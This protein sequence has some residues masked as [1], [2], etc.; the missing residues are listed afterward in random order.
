MGYSRRDGIVRAWLSS[1]AVLA[2]A[3]GPGRVSAQDKSGAERKLAGKTVAILVADAF[4]Q[5]ELTGPRKALEAG[6]KTVLVSPH[7]GQVRAWN[8]TNWGDIFDVDRPLD[9]A[10]PE[11]FDALLLSGGVG[12]PDLLRVNGDA[13]KFVRAFF[14]AGKPA[15]SI[16]H[17]PWTLIE[18]GVVKCRRM[19]SWPSLKTDLQ[20]AGATWENKEVVMDSN[21]VTSRMPSDIPVLNR[22]MIDLFAAGEPGTGS[23]SSGAARR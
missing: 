9:Q 1:L 5:V 22:H 14:D 23:A 13:V 8:L 7:G 10:R 2:I 17:G 3:A 19:T 6:A 12:N 20:N 15:A 21:L 4:E 16:C 18:A 11:Q